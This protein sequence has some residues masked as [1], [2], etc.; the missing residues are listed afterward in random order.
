MI[1]KAGDLRVG[2]LVKVVDIKGGTRLE[3]VVSMEYID[4]E[5]PVVIFALEHEDHTFVSNGIVS[6]NIGFKQA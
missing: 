5:M 3:P 1:A 6:H 4:M 2:D